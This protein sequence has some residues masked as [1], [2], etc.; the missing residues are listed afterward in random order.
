MGIPD[1]IILAQEMYKAKKELHEAKR[2]IVERGQAYT[3]AEKAYRI[4]LRQE[5]LKLKREGYPA[6]LI[7]DL[8]RGAVAELKY[9]RDDAEQI[10]K[11]ARDFARLTET[12][13]SVLQSINKRHDNI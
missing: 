6:T 13:I 4:A 11:S 12:E 10:Y 2:K 5:I 7:N 1:S 9:A 3:K 8:A